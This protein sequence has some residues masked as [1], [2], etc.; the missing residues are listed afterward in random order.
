MRKRGEGSERDRWYAMT[1]QRNASEIEKQEG[2]KTELNPKVLLGTLDEAI[3]ASLKL[4][5]DRITVSGGEH[6]QSHGVREWGELGL[7]CLLEDATCA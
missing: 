2:R 3:P 1:S 7:R 4:K 5:E 6:S